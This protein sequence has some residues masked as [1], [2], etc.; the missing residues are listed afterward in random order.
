MP[1]NRTSIVT[2]SVMQS[3]KTYSIEN[4]LN[5]TSTQTKQL[6]KYGSGRPRKSTEGGLK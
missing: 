3:T 4:P 1:I 5:P 6:Q 2:Q